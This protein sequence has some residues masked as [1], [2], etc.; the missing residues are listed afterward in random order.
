MFN[1]LLKWLSVKRTI[2]N[3]SGN[4]S[5]NEDEYKL[6][7]TEIP[8]D[9]ELFYER[10]FFAY[11]IFKEGQ[12]AHSKISD[13]VD[14]V[15]PD[16][17]PKKMHM[18]DGVPVIPYEDDDNLITKGDKIYF[19]DPCEAYEIISRT[20]PGNIYKWDVV[21]IDDVPFNVLVARN[22][23]GCHPSRDKDGNYLDSYDGRND[24][25]FCK[26]TKF[27]V[28]EMKQLDLEDDYSIFKIQMYYMLLWSAIDRYCT[29]KY[30][31][32]E[33]QGNYLKELANDELFDEAF[34]FIQPRGRD[35]IYSS[36][37][38]SPFYFNRSRPN[39]IVNHYY[40]I[41]C[42]VVHRGKD[43]ENNMSSLIESLYDLLKIFQYM[44][45]KTF[46]CPEDE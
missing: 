2:V 30:D 27:I 44:I 1:V 46:D 23:K 9:D 14:K 38:A 40:T 24:P 25:F 19:K 17:I 12:L 34:Q 21:F 31:V 16:E 3:I 35:A 29:L 5:E 18:R 43:P 22:L 42:N 28:N 7:P 8:L 13:Y 6:R 32:H 10:P 37:N 15:I 45:G 20:Q 11:G 26:A 41:R 33:D 36:K 4:M 39:Y